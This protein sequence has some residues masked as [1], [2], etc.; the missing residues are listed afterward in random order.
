MC[1]SDQSLAPRAGLFPSHIHP[2]SNGRFT[3]LSRCKSNHTLP[4]PPPAM[5]SWWRDTS[6]V[7]ASPAQ[8]RVPRTNPAPA[9]GA[10]LGLSTQPTAPAAWAIEFWVSTPASPG[11][12]STH[13]PMDHPGDASVGMALHCLALLPD[14][15]ILGHPAASH[16][17]QA[18]EH[19][20]PTSQLLS[21]ALGQA[22]QCCSLVLVSQDP[23]ALEIR[24]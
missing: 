15:K 22:G 23:T 17:L 2:R 13:S 20:A 21:P 12:Q 4:E 10:A 19:S 9:R 7:T 14:R 5:Q 3:A 8:H 11:A 24:I 1:C 16:R 18:A 6:P